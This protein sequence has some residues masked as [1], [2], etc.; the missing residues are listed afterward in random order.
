MLKV[1]ARARCGAKAA[2]M[3]AATW[4][5]G[6]G[7]A[8]AGDRA[9]AAVIG[10]SADGRYAAYEQYGVQD[11]SGYP[12]AQIHIL[13]V[14][15]GGPV[16]GAPFGVMLTEEDLPEPQLYDEGLATARADVRA[17]AA[18]ALAAHGIDGSRQ[19][20][21][22]LNRLTGDLNAPEREARFSIDAAMG[23]TVRD[24]LLLRLNAWPAASAVCESYGVDAIQQLA[25]ELIQR[26]GYARET[27][28]QD[29]GTVEGRTCP[30]SYRIAQIVAFAPEQGGPAS[31]AESYVLLVLIAVEELPGFEGPDT[32][33]FGLAALVDVLRG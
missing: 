3:I 18:D 31:M 15:A 22:V 28:L 25:V 30:G 23:L 7:V 17:L 16:Q 27:L 24:D 11:G 4:L 10:F 12:Y 8:Q 1:F 33:Y 14:A 26:G 32:R 19:G 29:D 5:A 13:D 2:V 6:A 20:I 9:E 21:A